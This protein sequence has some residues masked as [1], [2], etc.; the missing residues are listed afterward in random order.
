MR[1]FFK[2]FFVIAAAAF[3]LVSCV[4]ENDAPVSGTKTV[5]FHASSVE[6]KTAFGEPDGITY[7]TLWTANDTEIKVSL[8]LNSPKSVDVYPSDDYTTADFSATLEDDGS[9]SYV[10]YS[11]SPASAFNSFHSTNR[12]LSANIPTSQTPLETSVD[13][14]A[15]VL[16]AISDEYS[17]MPENVSLIY[18][19]FTAYGKL[20]FVNLNLDGAKVLSVAVSSE[21]NLAGR[22]N[23]LVDDDAF[24]VNSGASTVTINTSSTEDIWFAC[25]P[26]DLSNKTLTI[27]VNTDKGPLTKDIKMASGRK[28]EAG[29]IAK[30]TVD[31]KDAE[32]AESKT[33]HLV[34]ST[35][36][37]T[38]GS[39]I[40]IVANNANVALSTTQNG[41]NRGQAAV[42]K[43]SDGSSISDPGTDVQILTI[44]TG[45]TEG[46]VA[47]NTGTGY[48]YAASSS[49]NYLRTETSLSANSSWS[50]SFEEGIATIKAQGSNTRNWLRY[51]SSSSIF[52][53]YGSGQQDVSIYKL[54]GSG[55][56]GSGPIEP[57]EPETPTE[58]EEPE[59]LEE[60]TIE[61]FKNSAQS[62]DGIWY[63][64]T[65]TITDIQKETFGNF[66]ISDGEESVL[67]Y[68]MTNGWVG[69]NDQSFAQIGLKVGDIVTLGTLRGE[70]GGVAQGG[71]NEIPAYY[72]SHIPGETPTE[73]YVFKKVSVITS[74]KSY[75]VVVASEGKVAKPEMSK[76]YGYLNVETSTISNDEITLNSLTNAFVITNKDSGYTIKQSDG[77]YL[78][79][80]GNYNSFNYS[81]EPAEG[82]IWSFEL[83]SDGSFKI[84]NKLVEKYIQYSSQYS[85][86]GSYA[87]AQGEMPH[88]YEL[89]D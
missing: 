23:Y 25:A 28:F 89:V 87:D 49:K 77:R 8:N 60:V 15:Q 31:M 24:V 7:P 9:G 66:V 78:Y 30:F 35:D 56:A 70:Y 86:Y 65:G 76:A 3:A 82:D 29:R 47:F 5:Q 85:S 2:P 57:E 61:Y 16:Y 43:S 4:K 21:E 72:I 17:E 73:S 59:N 81:V 68:G 36:E 58:P 53:C 46:T 84:T 13:E 45:T 44:E 55:D 75:L 42:T 32:F 19:H 62:G 27:T 69:T 51:N 67:I 83:Q 48:L 34:N 1:K 41:N 20:S 52:A 18:K 80:T 74:G 40:I 6:T 54:E 63:Q 26:V 88:L 64:L 50:V 71:G 11:M 22:W 33:Y 10:F 37:L 12:Y 14:S 39:E 38:T 79:Q